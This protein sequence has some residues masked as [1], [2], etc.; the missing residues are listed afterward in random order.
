M[1]ESPSVDIIAGLQ[2]AGA[3][4]QAYDP[5]AMEASRG[6]LKDIRYCSDAYEAANGVDALLLITAWNEF[7][8][9]DME[10]VRSL[11][12]GSVLVDGRNIYDPAE[13]RD[14]GFTYAG[15]GRS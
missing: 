13:M 14:F 7:K 8:Q 5:I 10:K 3:K 1:R 12:R 15:V 2:A 11:M 6:C 9:L 4:V